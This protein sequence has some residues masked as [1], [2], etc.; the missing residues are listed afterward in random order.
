M[1]T[2]SQTPGLLNIRGVVG[3]DFSCELEI[4]KDVTGYQFEAGIVLQEYPTKR[5][6]AVTVTIENAGSGIIT[7]SL[8]GLQTSAIGAIANKKW[9]LNWT[10]GGI[11]QTILAGRFELSDIP[12]GQNVPS[13]ND[14]IIETPEV[15]ITLTSLTGAAVNINATND[16]TTNASFFPVFVASAGTGS[17][18]VAN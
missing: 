10:I 11:K 8:T 4:T 18:V 3:T 12:I 13:E 5:E 15:N 17:F 9:Y 16:T 6:Q 14:V 1:A 7:L 2:Y